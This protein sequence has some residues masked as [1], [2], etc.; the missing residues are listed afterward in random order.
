M[1]AR[2]DREAGRADEAGARSA[3]TVTM[4][5]PDSA[6]PPVLVLGATGGQGGAVAAALIRTGRPVRALVRDPAAPAARRLAA[7]GA[8]LATGDFT[9]PEALT[10]AMQ[11]SAAAFAL[12]TPFESG[13]AAE[14][15]QGRAI[16]EAAAAARLGH[17]VFSSVAGAAQETGIPHF[18]SKAAVERVL[19]ASGL[20]YTIVA[21]TYFYDNALGG[22]EQLRRG[23]LELPLPADHQLQQL[24]RTALGSFVELVLRDPRAFAGRRI[25]L[26]SDA[27][28]PAQMSQALS[29]ALGHPV[30]FG[31][32]PMSAVRQGS[33]DMAAMWGFLR[34]RGYQA[35]IGA[36]HRDYPEVAWTSFLAWAQRTAG[37]ALAPRAT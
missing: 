19:G 16:I 7:A 36:L 32:V 17:L 28:T 13:P 2:R 35:D 3:D 10:A 26:A 18:D 30:R 8:Q 11:H 24:D 1:T 4:T 25:E 23:V 14:L 6:R 22:A 20:P 29:T 31:E 21:P 9:N 27:P 33:P 12:T 15:E 37:P 5:T 34:G